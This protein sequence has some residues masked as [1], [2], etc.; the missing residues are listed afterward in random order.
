MVSNMALS[1]S[2]LE[3]EKGTNDSLIVNEFGQQAHEA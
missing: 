2:H 3:R 1:V